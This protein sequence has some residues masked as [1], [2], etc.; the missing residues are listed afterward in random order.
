MYSCTHRAV[1]EPHAPPNPMDDGCHIARGSSMSTASVG[2]MQNPIL[3][4]RAATALAEL[5]R[6]YC[7][8][9]WKCQWLWPGAP[10]DPIRPGRTP[11]VRGPSRPEYRDAC[12]D[13]EAFE[14]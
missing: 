5:S 6:R 8:N 3:P 13:G 9:C 1:G 14:R 12:L 10:S 11:P 7:A 2:A 4:L